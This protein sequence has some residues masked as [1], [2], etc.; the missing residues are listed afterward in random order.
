[1]KIFGFGG[2]NKKCVDFFIGVEKCMSALSQ[3]WAAMYLCSSFSCISNVDLTCII[4]CQ[5]FQQCKIEIHH[6]SNERT[7]CYSVE[8]KQVIYAQFH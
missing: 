5:T 6:A 3:C 4:I 7:V 2:G 1:M 8:H